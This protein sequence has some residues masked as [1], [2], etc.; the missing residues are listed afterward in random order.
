MYPSQATQSTRSLPD[1]SVTDKAHAGGGLTH[2]GMNAIDL[3]ITLSELIEHPTV[4]A[5]VSATVNLPAPDIKGIHMSRLYQRLLPFGDSELLTPNA[6]QRLLTDMISS[7][8]TCSS[9]AAE[10]SFSFILLLK[11][12]ALKTLDAYG[13]SHYPVEIRARMQNNKT[14][15]QLRVSVGYSSTCPCSAALSRQMIAEQFLEDFQ[16]DSAN[17]NAETVAHW[18][19]DNATY[20]TPHSQRSRADIEVI[21]DNLSTGFGL[22]SLIGKIENA[23]QTPLQTA[24]KRIDEQA[25]ARLNGSNLMFVEDAARRLSSAL[26]PHYS[27]LKVDVSH[28]ESLHPHD[29]VASFSA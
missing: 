5:R 28:F 1:V 13:W 14:T 11:K 8:E 19:K 18:L 12:S 6:L 25:F 4:N 16:H 24:V 7:H 26:S 2:V 15:I 9:T 29:A 23:L 10:V 27:G 20:A 3:P 21:I 17:L 22:T